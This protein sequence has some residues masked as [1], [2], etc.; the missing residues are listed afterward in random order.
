MTAREANKKRAPKHPFDTYTEVDS[1]ALIDV[2][3]TFVY[4]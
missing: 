1:Q 2:T 3:R 4:R